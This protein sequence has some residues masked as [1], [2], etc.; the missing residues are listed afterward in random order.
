MEP[1]LTGELS[2]L[3]DVVIHRPGPELDRMVPENLEATI[4]DNS[5]HIRDNP[6]YLLFDD[7]VL[8]SKLQK[9][10]DQI[11]KVLR[12]CCGDDHAHQVRAWR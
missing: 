4:S 2:R 3:R 7:L 5:G 10:H 12:A 6:N 1:K 9:E 11:N 8:L